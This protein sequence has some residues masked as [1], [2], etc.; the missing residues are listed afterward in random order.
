V[1]RFDW[2]ELRIELRDGQLHVWG[3]D[4]P[5][6]KENCSINHCHLATCE[7]L[8]LHEVVELR[9]DSGRWPV[10]TIGTVVETFAAGAMVEIAD[11]DGHT[12]DLIALPYAAL[13][14]A[15]PPEQLDADGYTAISVVGGDAAVGGV[16]V[17]HTAEPASRSDALET[18]RQT[19]ETLR[20][21]GAT[22]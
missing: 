19:G 5:L 22:S 7:A 4:E 21:T 14:P 8:R 11:E 20:Q 6:T 13:R 9:A 15:E 18:L 17:I 16:L 1:S 10:G 12:L 2:D 3:K